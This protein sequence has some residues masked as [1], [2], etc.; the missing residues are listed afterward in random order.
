M[1]TFVAR[2]IIALLAIT[3]IPLA[4]EVFAQEETVSTTTDS[5]ETAPEVVEAPLWYKSERIS[6]NIEVG[7]FVVGPGRSEITAKPGETVTVEVS[8]TNRINTGRE[9][10]LSVE[11]IE[12]TQDGTSMRALPAGQ[13]SPIGLVDFVSFQQDSLILDIGE[14]ARIPVKVT[15]PANASPGGYFGA[16]MVSTVRDAGS[17]GDYA[18]RSPLIARVASLIFLTVE[19]DVIT[20]GET[21]NIETLNKFENFGWWYESGPIELGILYENTGTVHLNPYAEVSIKNIIGEEVGY[22]QLEPW[23]VLPKALRVREFT[24]DREFLFGYY[25]VEARV[26]RGYEDQIDTVTTSFWVLP[27]KLVGSIFIGLFIIIFA[28]RFFFRTFEFKRKGS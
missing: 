5:A 14:R 10:F 13:K 15:V 4:G 7:D 12:G 1:A 24:W 11:D 8:V 9:F 26:N 22:I 20:E 28:V 18:P 2:F 25:T 23:F 21:L 17:G 6:G 19:G 16:V 3:Q 27:W